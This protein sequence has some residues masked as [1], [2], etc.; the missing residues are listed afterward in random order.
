MKNRSMLVLMGLILLI[1]STTWA[2]MNKGAADITLNGGSTGNV[3]F[4]HHVHQQA[5]DQNCA[6]CHDLF[7]Q[8]SGAIDDL[9]NKGELKKQQVMNKLCLK[10]HREKKRAGEKT[11]PVSCKKCH[12]K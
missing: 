5:L 3:A 7:P 4:P 10:C 2:V 9:K 12:N 6:T 1:G 8:Q 11:G